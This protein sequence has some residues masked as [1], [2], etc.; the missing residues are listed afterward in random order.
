MGQDALGQGAHQGQQ[1]GQGG[2][3]DGQS[4]HA[5]DGARDRQRQGAGQDLAGQLEAEKDR[6]GVDHARQ[7]FA[8]YG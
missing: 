3:G 5:E 1:F 4:Y 2:D 7:A 8:I 6:K